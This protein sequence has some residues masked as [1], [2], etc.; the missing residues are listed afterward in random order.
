MDADKSLDLPKRRGEPW[1]PL[2]L[3]CPLNA[4]FSLSWLAFNSFSRLW[5]LRL[6]L[7]SSF[8]L[9]LTCSSKPVLIFFWRAANS[10][11]CLVFRVLQ[12][13]Y[14]LRFRAFIQA[15]FSLFSRSWSL[16]WTLWASVY[17]NKISSTVF[18]L[19]YVLPFS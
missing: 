16:A 5:Y 1:P 2:L 12:A 10:A 3:N 14:I 18:V 19:P 8:P 17:L 7:A 6:I 15:S 13:V 4:N 9:S 11:A